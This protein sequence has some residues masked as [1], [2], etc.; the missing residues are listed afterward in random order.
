MARITPYLS[1]HAMLTLTF[2]FQAKIC[3]PRLEFYMS[4]H[5]NEMRFNHVPCLESL[6][7]LIT[8]V[9]TDSYHT[10]LS[11]CVIKSIISGLHRMI[12]YK[13]NSFVFKPKAFLMLQDHLYTKL[14]CLFVGSEFLVSHH[15]LHTLR[16]FYGLSLLEL[17]LT[18]LLGLSP[19][20]VFILTYYYPTQFFLYHFIQPC[21]SV[22]LRPT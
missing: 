5:D 14:M 19:M 3:N 10:M 6:P 13:T 20:G 7:T 21:D 8:P 9:L 16:H 12:I 17:C 4:C 2:T 18:I 11:P 22:G 15:R 1:A